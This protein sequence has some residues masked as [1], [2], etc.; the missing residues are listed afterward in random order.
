[1]RL[2]SW[3]IALPVVA[4]AM[5]FAVSNHD[6]VTI[7][8]WPAPYRLEVP[9]YIAV[10]GAL[11]TGFV[12]GVI[13]GWIGSLPARRRARSEAK[14]A[15]KLAAENEDLRHK[16]N[17]AENAARSVPPPATTPA[18]PAYPSKAVLRHLAGGGL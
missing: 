10:T 11:L 4:L 9:L 1:M 15:D 12:I 5:A 18:T 2:I 17:L 14:R 6:S 8:L 3:L 16:L 13:Y 7:D